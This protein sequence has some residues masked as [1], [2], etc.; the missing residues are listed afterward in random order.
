MMLWTAVPQARDRR[1]KKLAT[2]RVRPTGGHGHVRALQI[3][4]VVAR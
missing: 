1:F 2:G 3:S 4:S